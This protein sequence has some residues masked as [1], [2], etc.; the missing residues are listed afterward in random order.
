MLI[1][2]YFSQVK[3]KPSLPWVYSW[4]RH[5]REQVSP[6]LANTLQWVSSELVQYKLPEV[7][8]GGGGR[9]LKSEKQLQSTLLNS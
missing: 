9:K 8:F 5:R 1:D 6:T 2:V 7:F 4:I 3:N